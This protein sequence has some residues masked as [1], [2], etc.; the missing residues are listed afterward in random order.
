MVEEM[1]PGD[2]ADLRSPESEDL[3]EAIAEQYLQ[4]LREAET[5]D[6]KA[7]V[8]AHPQIAHM[9]RGRLA[10]MQAIHEGRPRREP[11]GGSGAGEPGP[12]VDPKLLQPKA[13]WEDPDA[14]DRKA[15]ELANAFASNFD[16]IKSEDT[17]NL[18]AVGPRGR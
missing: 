15:A 13:T 12:D 14:Y 9:L 3:V 4:K 2:P 6:L 10:L 11:S 18:A 7:I 8:A 1:P 5:P 17:S 16:K